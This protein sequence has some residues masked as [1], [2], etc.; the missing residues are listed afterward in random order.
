M[1]KTQSKVKGEQEGRT[2]EER[3]Q[4]REVWKSLIQIITFTSNNTIIVYT[5]CFEYVHVYMT[6][7][8]SLHAVHSDKVKYVVQCKSVLNQ[9]EI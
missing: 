3:N 6:C 8:I 5:Y 4:D 7:C 2:E 1:R 9:E